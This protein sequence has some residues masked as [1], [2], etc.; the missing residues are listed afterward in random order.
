MNKG[1][2]AFT[3]AYATVGELVLSATAL[4]HQMNHVIIE[5][6]SLAKSPMLESVVATLDHSRKIE[7]LKARAQHIKKGSRWREPVERY[8]KHLEQ[9]SRARNIACHSPMIPTNGEPVFAPVAAAKLLRGLKLNPDQ[10]SGT[11]ERTP[12]EVLRRAIEVS[13]KALALGEEIIAYFANMNA[14]RSQ[15]QDARAP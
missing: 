11:S 7:I 12:I 1:D 14:M 10:R 5:V 2:D 8:V 15:R 9:V 13:R 3:R 6:T 4:D